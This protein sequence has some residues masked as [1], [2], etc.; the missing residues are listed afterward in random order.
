MTGVSEAAASGSVGDG[1]VGHGGGLDLPGPG[2]V[3]RAPDGGEHERPAQ[4]LLRSGQPRV[5]QHRVGTRDQPA[6]VHEGEH[7]CTE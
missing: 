3:L 4:A 5:G 7:T 1:G 2:P 6:D